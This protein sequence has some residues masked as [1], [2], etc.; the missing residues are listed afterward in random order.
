MQQHRPALSPS[1][2]QDFY[3]WTQHQARL[4]RAADQNGSH[5]PEGLDLAHLAEEVEDLG[6]SELRGTVSLIQQ[7]MV[8]LIKAA[9]DAQ[10]QAGVTGELR[11]KS[12][13]PSCVDTTNP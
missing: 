3:G 1:Y 10:G 12:F 9:S 8:H 6:K 11:R 4:L 5:V 2:D 13:A 7:I